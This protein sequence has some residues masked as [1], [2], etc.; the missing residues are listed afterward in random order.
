VSCLSTMTMTIQSSFLMQHYVKFLE[1][2]ILAEQVLRLLVIL[3]QF[4]EKFR[5]DRWHNRVSFRDCTVRLSSLTQ[6]LE[7]I[8]CS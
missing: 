5:S 8:L 3:E 6:N 7:R 4:V 2:A 1:Q